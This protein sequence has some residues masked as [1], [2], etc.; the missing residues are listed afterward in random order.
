MLMQA[1]QYGSRSKT[2][3]NIY[4]VTENKIE[5]R[6]INTS[7]TP[8]QHYCVDNDGTVWIV[9]KLYGGFLADN[10]TNLTV[11]KDGFNSGSFVTDGL[12]DHQ[13]KIWFCT[14]LS[15][16]IYGAETDNTL[17]ECT[18][19]NNDNSGYPGDFSAY[20]ITE[21]AEGNIWLG[22]K[23]GLSIIHRVNAEI[24]GNNIIRKY[25]A[26]HLVMKNG[27]RLTVFP[28]D[29]SHMTNF[30][31]MDLQG[32]TLVKKNISGTRNST[33]VLEKNAAGKYIYQMKTR[34]NRI[35]GHFNYIK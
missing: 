26:G 20:A 32:R 31:I 29:P 24:K 34:N 25:S 13:G 1:I 30:R 33:F 7:I 12:V 10:R 5:K 2:I 8:I 14:S 18:I 17:A 4:K 28:G 3:N 23:F 21:D 16:L 11:F 27:A 22:G 35:S 9:P 15:G 19:F 6:E